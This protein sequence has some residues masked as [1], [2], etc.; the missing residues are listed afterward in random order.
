MYKRQIDVD[1]EIIDNTW[2]R[3]VESYLQEHCQ[4]DLDNLQCCLLYTS[5]AELSDDNR[6]LLVKRA[7]EMYDGRSKRKE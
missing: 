3:D 5:F 6:D 4:Y 2:H 7:I 1:K